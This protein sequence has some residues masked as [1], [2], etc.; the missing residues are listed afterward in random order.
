MCLI[1]ISL[2]QHPRYKL[3]IAANRD[4]FHKRRTASAEF[5]PD[6]PQILGG[7]DLEA[8][9]TWL[10]MSRS[11]KISLLT[12]YRDL[13]N[14][15]PTAPSRGHLVSDFLQRPES[16]EKYLQDVG[17]RGK[18]YNGFN[19]L[20]GTT[21][22]LWYLSNYEPGIRKLL[23]GVHGLSNHLMDTPWPKVELGKELFRPIL[24]RDRID[25]AE[26]LALLYNDQQAPDDQ[27]PDTGV[28]L[29]R[30]RVLSAMF[31]KSPD[32]GSRSSTVVLV[33]GNHVHFVERVYDLT[34]FN[35]TT[36]EFEFDIPRSV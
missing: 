9:G 35:Y 31:I 3:V 5:W 24:G 32:Y 17:Q 25:P 15:N 23:P 20:A 13:S 33:E 16:A 26:L 1:F 11:G 22:D 30:E 14:I 27:L 28:G 7:R 21:D 8:K 2:Q 10:A 29:E 4:E 19:L 36:R 34:T 12:N 18:D 6:V